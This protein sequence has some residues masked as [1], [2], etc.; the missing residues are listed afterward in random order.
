M[1][2]FGG[3]IRVVDANPGTVSRL[4]LIAFV[5]GV[6]VILMWASLA[7]VPPGYVGVLT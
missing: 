7:Y 5:A 6:I 4:I 2:H 3:P 1:S